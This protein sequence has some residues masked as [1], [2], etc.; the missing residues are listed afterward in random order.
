MEERLKDNI[1]NETER[2]DIV[3][4]IDTLS[5]GVLFENSKNKIEIA[6]NIRTKL[7]MKYDKKTKEIVY[8]GRCK[9]Y[10]FY[11]KNKYYF[12]AVSLKHELIEGKTKEEVVEETTY[13]INKY[14]NAGNSLKANN[15]NRIDYKNDYKCKNE[16][17]IEIVKNLFKKAVDKTSKKCNKIITSK[18]GFY[19][20][21]YTSKGSGC[22][23]IACY[24]KGKEMLK[25][26]KKGKYKKKEANKYT[27]IFRVEL[28]IKN[29]RLNYEKHKNGI[30]K[31]IA[32]YYSREVAKQY[33]EYYV[34]KIFGKEKFYRIDVAVEMIQNEKTL[35][36]ST[37][38]KLCNL[39]NNINKNGYTKAIDSYKCRSTF[40]SYA[41]KVK[42]L[43]INVLTFDR[44][45]NGKEMI[46]KCIDN[47][48]IIK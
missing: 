1:I 22:V 33:F 32:N 28:R 40:L 14:F 39:L 44:V 23:E 4:V 19:K 18:D 10:S 25:Q 16:D 41:K 26:F 27:N 3:D 12:L 21:K 37:K 48:A 6:N 45:I 46:Q 9:G 5:F 7:N 42:E 2:K 15:L 31:D 24:D 35:K 29:A 17:E 36:D 34:E 43:G 11:F 30:A 13:F 47:F 20:A 38:E 8:V